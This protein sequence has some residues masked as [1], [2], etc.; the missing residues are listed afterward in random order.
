MND[1]SKQCAWRVAK[2]RADQQLIKLFEQW[3][4]PSKRLK[5]AMQYAVLS[6]GKRLRPIL[7]YLT[8]KA[9]NISLERL[10]SLACAVECMHAYSLIHDDLP[11]MDDD[12]LRRGK[13]TCH[14]A[15]DEATAILAGDALQALAFQQILMT[16]SSLLSAEQKNSMASLLS[17]ACG[18]EG[19]VSGQ[20]MD[21]EYLNQDI[22]SEALL[23][24][25]HQLKTGILLETCINLAILALPKNEYS[26]NTN[27]H[28]IYTQHLSDFGQYLGLAFQIQDDYLD[29]YGDTLLLGKQQGADKQQG[30]KTYADLYSREDLLNLINGTYKKAMD[31]LTLFEEKAGNKA[32]DLMDFTGYLAGRNT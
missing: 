15:F 9:L 26:E 27:S 6:S 29:V 17:F 10:D 3:S 4:V 30:K 12:D 24:E 18:A 20:A 14:R 31:C 23:K 8:G 21:L 32:T 1:D 2:D 25:I 5:E 28:R 11:A 16:D 13:P 19:M 7:I 22:L